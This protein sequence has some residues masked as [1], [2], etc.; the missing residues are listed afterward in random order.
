MRDE[1]KK[2]KLSNKKGAYRSFS[3][4]SQY[5]GTGGNQL[6]SIFGA[7]LNK[8]DEGDQQKEFKKK[9]RIHAA[10]IKRLESRFKDYCP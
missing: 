1:K 4:N 6:L 2:K 10:Q 8:K 3:S 9:L 5:G 7:L